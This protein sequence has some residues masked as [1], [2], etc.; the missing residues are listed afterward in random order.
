MRVS[1]VSFERSRWLLFFLPPKLSVSVRVTFDDMEDYIIRHHRLYD[2]VIIARKPTYITEKQ[3]VREGGK[4]QTKLVRR[5]IDHSIRLDHLYQ[6][7][8]EWPMPHPTAIKALIEE[9]KDGL[10]EMKKFLVMNG[11]RPDPIIWM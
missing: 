5:E 4:F 9:L 1:I 2:H 8:P 7:V 6:R 3:V 11:S 10:E